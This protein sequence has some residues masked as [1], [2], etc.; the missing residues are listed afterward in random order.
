MS[1]VNYFLKSGGQILGEQGPFELGRLTRAPSVPKLAYLRGNQE[2]LRTRPC[3]GIVGTRKPSQTGLKRA[4][5]YA[6][7]LSSAGC[8]V[9][10]GGALGIDLAAHRGALSVGCETLA[11]LGDPVYT[12]RDERPGR[13]L[14]LEPAH[15]VSTVTTCG[16]G[17]KLGRTL[18]VSRNQYIAALSDAILIIEGT[19]NSGTLHTARYAQKIGVPVWAI[20]GDP[21][22]PR[23]S[24]ANFL[25]QSQSARALFNLEALFES[26]GLRQDFSD[27]TQSAQDKSFWPIFKQHGGRVTLDL[28]C[29]TLHVPVSQIQSDL[30]ELELMGTI[31]REGAEF[32]WQNHS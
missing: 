17:T 26:L 15:L 8:L 23:A 20:P 9:V 29:D 12:D 13:I 32:I 16:P 14:D 24:A 11:V 10:S 1:D 2:L 19:L 27:K 21:D 30:L 5:D 31:Y 3:V 4:F 18:F 28:L 25:L 22:N 6:A 7:A